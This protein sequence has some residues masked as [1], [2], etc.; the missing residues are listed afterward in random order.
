MLLKRELHFCVNSCCWP[1][2]QLPFLRSPSKRLPRRPL[3]RRCETLDFLFSSFLWSVS[4]AFHESLCSFAKVLV[5]TRKPCQSV[6]VAR[7]TSL[8]LTLDPR[9]LPASKPVHDRVWREMPVDQTFQTVKT[10]A[11]YEQR[12]EKGAWGGHFWLF[13]AN[14]V[15]WATLL[16]HEGNNQIENDCISLELTR[17]PTTTARFQSL[18]FRQVF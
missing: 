3:H 16:T 10:I 11:E 5:R 17:D 6:V 13:A 7:E 15:N 18:C 9:N 2:L 12:Q 4:T 1:S 8:S 14:N